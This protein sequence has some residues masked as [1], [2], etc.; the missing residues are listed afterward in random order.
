MNYPPGRSKLNSQ[1]DN[2]TIGAAR[3]H[4]PESR[5]TAGLRSRREAAQMRYLPYPGGDALPHLNKFE[6]LPLYD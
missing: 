1:R 5:D 4:A 3:I 6:I 2:R